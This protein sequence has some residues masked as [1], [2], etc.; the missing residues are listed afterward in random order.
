M[1]PHN[2]TSALAKIPK[3][4]NH[5][6]PHENRLKIF[7]VFLLCLT[8]V[9]GI[10]KYLLMHNSLRLDEAQSLWQT[11]HSITGTLKVVAQ[12]V[13]VPLYHLIL[14]FWQFYLGQDIVAARLLS[15]I[16]FIATIPVVYLIA[17][18][19]LSLNWSLLAVALFSLSPFMNWYA[20]EAR[21]YTL[22]VFVSALSQYF[23]LKVIQSRGKKG[24]LAYSLTALVGIYSHYFFAFNLLAQGIFFVLNRKSFA[25]GTLKKFIKLAIGLALALAPWLYY[26]VLLGAASNTAPNLAAPSTVDLFN[27]FSQF[28]FGFQTDAANT[29]LVSTWPILVAVALFAVRRGQKVGLPIAYM[30]AAGLLPIMLAFALSFAITPFFLSRYMVSCVAPLTIAVVWFISN[31]GRNL[32]KVVTAILVLVISLASLQQYASSATPV[33]EDYRAAAELIGQSATPDDAVIFVGA[34]H[35]IPV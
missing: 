23:F 20:N 22:L 14:H 13:H 7:W 1:Q 28:S 35:D 10:S 5:T 34:V 2:K 29:I 15:L 3:E 27:A 16:F 30:L 8:G 12:D 4:E 9:L 17:R 25:P 33:K 31:Y 19:I 32:S 11:S 26:F 21:M 6:A 18:R 24:W